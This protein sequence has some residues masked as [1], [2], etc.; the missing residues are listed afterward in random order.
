MNEPN[1]AALLVAFWNAF[2][3]SSLLPVILTDMIAL[4]AMGRLPHLLGFG[5]QDLQSRGP[6][7]LGGLPSPF[8]RGAAEV[9]GQQARETAQRVVGPRAQA[10]GFAGSSAS[11]A[12]L[13]SA[14]VSSHASKS[15]VVR[16]QNRV[17]AKTM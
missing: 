12:L 14:T 3:A 10:V 17:A 2:T 15:S 5:L 6:V 11:C 4:C 1:A 13:M 16:P 9:A 8:P 7:R